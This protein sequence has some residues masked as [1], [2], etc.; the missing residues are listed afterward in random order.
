MLIGTIIAPLVVRV[1]IVL[2]STFNDARARQNKS[3]IS[4]VKPLTELSGANGIPVL[5]LRCCF[6]QVAC[7]GL[8]SDLSSLF[9]L[10]DI[11]YNFDAK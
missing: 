4:E 2:E 8:I 3:S 9:A 7:L 6:V 5:R 11:A 10:A 1:R